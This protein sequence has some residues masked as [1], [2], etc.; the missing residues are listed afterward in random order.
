MQGPITVFDSGAYAGDARIEDLSP[1]ADRLLSYGLDLSTEVDPENGPGRDDLLTVAVRKGTIFATRKQSEEKTYNIR[2]HDTKKKTLII[3][4]PYRAD[5]KIVEPK[6]VPERTRDVYRFTVAVDAG[7]QTK[8]VVRQ[9][10]QISQTAMLVNTPND[11]FS[12]Y[13]RAQKISPAVKEAF[14]KVADMRNALSKTTDDRSR[15]EQHV[16]EITQDQARIR[17]NMRTLNQSS[18]LYNGYVNNMTAQEKELASVR[19]DIETQKD[20]QTKQQREL[21]DYILNLDVE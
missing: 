7:A 9:E 12:F 11:G 13:L 6:E 1:K 4:H 20:K 14:Q 16:S 10:K 19:K 15:L 17:E 5:W 21:N 18:D 2:S 3:E 8:L